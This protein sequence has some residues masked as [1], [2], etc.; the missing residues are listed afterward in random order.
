[1]QKS[2]FLQCD[3]VD[4]RNDVF[5]SLDKQHNWVCS[6]H[7]IYMLK[8]RYLR[9]LNRMHGNLPPRIQCTLQRKGH[10]SYSPR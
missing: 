6:Q 9:T 3:Y 5:D 10:Q 2:S 7:M 1:M 4:Y 8:I